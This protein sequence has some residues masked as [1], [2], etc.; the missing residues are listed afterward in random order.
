MVLCLPYLEILRWLMEHRWEAAY[1][2]P[3]GQRQQMTFTSPPAG[4]LLE[5]PVIR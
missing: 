4:P 2:W 5:K 3:R 1:V